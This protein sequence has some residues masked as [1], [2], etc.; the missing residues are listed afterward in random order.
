MYNQTGHNYLLKF[1]FLFMFRFMSERYFRLK[2]RVVGRALAKI[3]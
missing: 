3:L 2:S 1:Y